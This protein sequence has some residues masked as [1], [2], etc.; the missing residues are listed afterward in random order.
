MQHLDEGTI[1]AWLDG[2][3]PL[4]E[5]EAAGAHVALCAECAAAVAEARGFIAASSRILTALDAVPGGV[6]PGAERAFSVPRGGRTSRRLAIPR[7]WMAVAA[8]LVLGIGAVIATRPRT[9]VAALRVA[10]ERAEAKPAIVASN[11]APRPVPSTAPKAAPS[12]GPPA[13]DTVSVRDAAPARAAVDEKLRRESANERPAFQAPVPKDAPA[14]VNDSTPLMIAQAAPP[15]A[16]ALDEVVVTGAGTV[17][18][19]GAV[20]AK[21]ADSTAPRVVSR[22]TTSAAGDSVVTTIYDVH[23]VRVS[24]TERQTAATLERADRSNYGDALMAKTR[25]SQPVEHSITWSDS[26]GRTRTLRGAMT[27]AELERL[28]AELFGATP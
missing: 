18:A 2:E 26:A 6:L 5:R 13:V 14:V 4:A 19:A 9:D 16:P 28:K 3:L 12:A 22:T 15:R 11:A 10:E 20:R 1:H 17:A 25:A 21:A 27:E 7:A 8:V 23:G 24:L